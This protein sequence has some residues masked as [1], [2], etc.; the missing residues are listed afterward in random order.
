MAVKHPPGSENFE[1]RQTSDTSFFCIPCF[2]HSELCVLSDSVVRAGAS[3]IVGI[4]VS[5]HVN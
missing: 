2:S 1:P 3:T 4:S 5:T